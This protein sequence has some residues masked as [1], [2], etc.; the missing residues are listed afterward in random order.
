MPNVNLSNKSLVD[1]EEQ[2]S[3][4]Q[5]VA[6]KLRDEEYGVNIKELIFND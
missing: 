6:F 1:D 2:I 5:I 3:A 4:M